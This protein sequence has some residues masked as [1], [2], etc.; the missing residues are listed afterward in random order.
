MT[1]IRP[2]E[3]AS[4][5]PPDLSGATFGRTADGMFAA[6]VGEHAFAMAPAVGGNHYLVS[7]WRI[8]RPIEEWTRA[9]FYGHG[10]ALADADAFRA[11]VLEQAQDQ[12]E[13]RALA[14][15][16]IRSTASTP[17]GPSQGATI[18]AEGVVCHS[19]AGHG[20][21]HLSAQR[22][23]KVH[24]SLRLSD[25]WYE[26]DTAWATVALTFPDLFTTYERRLAD[27]T[28]RDWRPEAWEAI[29][30]RPLGPGESREKDRWAFERL[31]ADDWIVASAILSDQHPGFTEVIAT[32]GGRHGHD[33][34]RRRFLV[35]SNEYKAGRFGFVVDP[36]R[37]EAYSGPSS[38][39]S[40]QAGARS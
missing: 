39:V 9:D 25:G 37:H 7:G 32:Q 11:K 18:F 1:P 20:G 6:L 4:P 3:I 24:A 27:Q 5:E 34:E 10:G 12:R 33:I 16:E 29:F 15:R 13:A 40:W 31:H 22:N 8:R 14:R 23:Q 17:W 38:F 35:P 28:I 21:F 36:D 2:P 26:E 30:G 19:T